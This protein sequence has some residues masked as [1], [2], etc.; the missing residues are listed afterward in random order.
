MPVSTA[1]AASSVD[2]RIRN[3]RGV[4]EQQDAGAAEVLEMRADQDGNTENLRHVGQRLDRVEQRA[5]IGGGHRL[6]A[7]DDGVRLAV[8]HHQ[9]AEIMRAGDDFLGISRVA[10][11]A[12]AVH[13]FHPLAEQSEVRG[14][15]RIDDVDEFQRNRVL[16]GQGADAL[17]V[18]EQDGRDDFLLHQPGGGLDDAD[19][20]ALGENDP[21][22]MPAELLEQVADD[23]VAGLGLCGKIGHG[24][25]RCL[26]GGTSLV[27]LLRTVQSDSSRSFMPADYHTHTPLCRHAEGEPEAYVDAALAAGLTEYGISDHA[28][29]VP[30]P[31]D[32]WRMLD[33][34]LPE[35]FHWIERARSPCR[36]PDSDPLP[37]WS[38][39]GWLA[40]NRGSPISP[41]ATSGTI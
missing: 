29:Q 38:A 4:G 34:E 7:A 26:H 37:G 31:F 5:E 3:Q 23:V 24:M 1:M 18:A 21:F 35:Y 39:T 8:L 22:R 27:C 15:R 28:P 33:A 16:R 2:V 36:G 13:V 6:V 19:V 40:A 41:R 32:D 20:L 12:V 14:Q 17:A 25:C 30:E 9:R 10:S 11:V